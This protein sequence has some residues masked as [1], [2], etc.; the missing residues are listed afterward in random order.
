MSKRKKTRV[1]KQALREYSKPVTQ[2]SDDGKDAK[3]ED[4][5]HAPPHILDDMNRWR[6]ALKNSLLCIEPPPEHTP[7]LPV[8]CIWFF[9]GDRPYQD[10]RE[11]S[12]KAIM[13]SLVCTFIKQLVDIIPPIFLRDEKA[14]SKDKF[15]ELQTENGETGALSISL[16]GAIEVIKA[17]VNAAPWPLF[18]VLADLH[19]LIPLGVHPDPD[20]AWQI[21]KLMRFLAIPDESRLVRKVLWVGAGSPFPAWIAELMLNGGFTSVK[22]E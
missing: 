21:K 18:F 3:F 19:V 4:Q 7:A 16:D 20:V 6:D 1:E 10:Q 12:T 14:L 9:A 5:H 13:A 8:H 11:V 17:L 22:Y 15:D 2:Y